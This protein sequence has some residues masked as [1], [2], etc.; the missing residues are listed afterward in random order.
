MAKIEKVDADILADLLKKFDDEV[1]D[2]DVVI[3]D[4]GNESE[5]GS[6]SRTVVFITD[7]ESKD[8]I[9]FN[10]A[11][12][13]TTL[14]AS[15]YVEGGVDYE[16]INAFNINSFYAAAALD[17]EGDLVIRASFCV[18]GGVSDK[19]V[20]HFIEHFSEEIGTLSDYMEGD[21]D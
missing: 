12:E 6:D 17:D 4:S 16:V 8:G 14:V 2:E 9:V 19:T 1:T 21:E 7:Q 18:D 15:F 3:S 11:H 20:K 5:D 10:F 13:G